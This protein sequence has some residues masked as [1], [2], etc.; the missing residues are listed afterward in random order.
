MPHA[1]RDNAVNRGRV[2]RVDESAELLRNRAQRVSANR[3]S[4]VLPAPVFFF[5]FFPSSST[6]NYRA[7]PSFLRV[8]PPFP[9]LFSF[10]PEK[11][12]IFNLN[13][14]QMD[15]PLTNYREQ[16]KNSRVPTLSLASTNKKK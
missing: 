9:L 14:D 15:F 5:L 1:N 8:R 16:G 4:T 13:R 10:A 11:L 12:E 7:K 3:R 6:R 2:Y